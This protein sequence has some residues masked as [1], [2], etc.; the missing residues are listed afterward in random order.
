[1]S[2]P[3]SSTSQTSSTDVSTS[4]HHTKYVHIRFPNGYDEPRSHVFLHDDFDLFCDT[5]YNVAL[6]LTDHLF[7]YDKGFLQ[8]ADILLFIENVHEIF[9]PYCSHLQT[10]QDL[11]HYPGL[12]PPN[13]TEVWVVPLVPN[14]QAILYSFIICSLLQYNAGYLTPLDWPPPLLLLLDRPVDALPQELTN[15]PALPG[16]S[17]AAP[18]P[19][20]DVNFPGPVMRDLFSP[21]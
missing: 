19:W 5:A 7:L 2:Q 9:V 20:L 3:T 4:A 15:Q 17:V 16:G 6:F 21:F 14:E 1:M 8:A 18:P 10:L 13:G 11:S 12:T